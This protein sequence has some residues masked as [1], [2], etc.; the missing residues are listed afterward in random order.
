MVATENVTL[1]L[2]SVKLTNRD[3]I[4]FKRTTGKSLPQAFNAE[5]VAQWQASNDPDFEAIAALTW[6][7]MRKQDPAFTYEDALDSTIDSSELL[8]VIQAMGATLDP[9]PPA[10]AKRSS[11][12]K[13]KS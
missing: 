5:A 1:D 7:L 13:S 8:E 11:R 12:T 6:V 2:S 4:D 3:M 10:T 9:T